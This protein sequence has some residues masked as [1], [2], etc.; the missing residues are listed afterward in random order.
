MNGRQ[1]N[2]DHYFTGAPSSDARSTEFT[3]VHSGVRLAMVAES[4]VFASRG[5]DKATAV[6]L[7]TI[8]RKGAPPVRDGSTVVD[9]GCGSGAIACA[10]AVTHPH[11]R[12]LAVDVNERARTLT[13]TNAARNGLLNVEVLAPADVPDD[14][15]VDA[16]WSNPPIRIGKDALHDLLSEWLP[17]LSPDG[18]AVLVVGRHL[19][20]DSLAA[21]IE[22][23][24]HRVER[25]A[26]SK[27]FR[28]LDVTRR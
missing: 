27:G 9:L 26:S 12:V 22:S 14:T 5:L 25:L 1:E 13:A 23:T 19:G 16:I 24:G 2:H 4:G 20:A 15:I 3:F 17:R 8:R 10:L 18:H 6:L 7:D 21:W 28:V 11:A